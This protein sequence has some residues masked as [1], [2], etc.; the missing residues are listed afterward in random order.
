MI[1]QWWRF[2][3]C[4]LLSGA[5]CFCVEENSKRALPTVELVSESEQAVKGAVLRIGVLIAIPEGEHIYWKNPGELGIPLR[6]SW[7]LPQGCE[8]LEEH[9]PTPEVFEEAGTVY[10]GYKHST[11]IVAD[12]R[13]SKNLTIDQLEIK[14]Q[15]EWL[16]CG[17]ACIPGSSLRTL[18]LPVG[19]GPLIPNS[20]EG[21]AFSR[22]LA[23]QPKPLDAAI[24]ISHHPDGLNV[25]V[26]EGKSDAATKAWFIAES[27]RDFACAEKALSEG[28]HTRVWQLKYP[29]GKMPQ[30]NRLFGILVFTND[31]GKVVA[32]YQIK[33]D[34]VQQF[35]TLGW[36]FFSI[37][38]MA[39][40]G[41]I[42]LNIMPCVL[43][44]IT[45]KVFSL[46][47]SAAD[48]HSSSFISGIWFTLGA[49]ASFWG[50]AIFAL[51]LKLLGQNIG[52]G[53]QLQEPM[54]V[55]VLVIIFFLFALSSL[56]VFEMGMICLSLGEKLQ[57]EGGASARKHQRWG[58]FFNGMLTTLVTTPCTGP[59]LGSVFGLVM[60]ISFVKQLAIFS[61]I[62][63][64]MASPYLLFASFPKML[65][66]L[67]KPGPW[68]N[69]F[70]QLTGFMLLAT[71]TWLIWIFGVETSSTAVTILLM[72]LWLSS[73][74]A[75][76]LGRWGTPV[77]PHR[78]RLLASTAFI[79]C[80]IG[81]FVIASVGVRYFDNDTPAVQNAQW[82]SFSP[83]KL[84][85]LREKGI[86]VFVNFTAKWCLT[87]QMNK[88]LLHANAP[89]F[90]S[91]GIVTLEADW[92][93]KDPRITEELAR[94]GRASVPS[95]VYYPS[96]SSAPVILPERLSQ[97]ILEETIF[98]K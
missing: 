39:F 28:E 32:S 57:E 81:S 6:I 33:S 62:G 27:T 50:L 10:F 97:K 21:L 11:M 73:I 93:K 24:T 82:E 80:I 96:G 52:W 20:A 16:S 5:S 31:A 71:A 72:G 40:V 75:W 91:M 74:G 2:F 12:V 63:L 77:S 79:F 26:K 44:L 56:G 19:P 53:F 68:M 47:K 98:S 34:Q 69:T 8:L 3:L 65:A 25:L 36:G 88:L 61:A 41:G 13:V 85:S 29:E 59:F 17:E 60:A 54:F 48:H 92:T 51:L 55:A 70:K 7:T 35:S 15:V 84:A 30:G 38:L 58:A 95:Y 4:F 23:A 9:W 14:A 64:G 18:V 66:I 1:Q 22:S 90:A 83:E 78:R 43:P 42:L 89:S 87:C 76:I 67:P 86:P 46:I 37:L 45:L 49:V 94:L